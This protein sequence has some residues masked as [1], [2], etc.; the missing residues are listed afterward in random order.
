MYKMKYCM[1]I[2]QNIANDIK[3]KQEAFKICQE[4]EKVDLE[5]LHLGHSKSKTM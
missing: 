1:L 4:L 3:Y 2:I 5:A